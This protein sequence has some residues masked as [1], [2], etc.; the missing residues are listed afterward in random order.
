MTFF[1]IV[2]IAESY[3]QR[4]TF[5]KRMKNAVR[6]IL[7]AAVIGCCSITA[8]SETNVIIAYEQ[9]NVGPGGGWKQQTDG[10]WYYQKNGEMLKNCWHESEG[11]W[12][13]FDESGKMLTG[14]QLIDG[15]QYY[16]TETADAT[17]P[18]GSMY[19]SESTPDG[20]AVDAD[21]KLVPKPEPTVSSQQTALETA[22]SRTNPYGNV[23]CVEISLGNQ[24]VY[25]YSGTQCIF[26]SPC[27]TGRVI[28]GNATPAGRF[29]IYNK[30]RNRTLRGFNADGSKYA[31][32]VSFWMP[33][34]GGIG[35]HDATWR[36]NFNADVYY[37]YGS[38]GC[39]NMPY[40][41]AAALY[42]IIYVG[43]PVYVHG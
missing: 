39:I 41:K 31:S 21:G 12:Y 33:F 8:Y 23:S 2:W 15:A 37:N 43:M 4:K 7:C 22:A 11:K 34:N 42:N 9:S 18:L 38:H 40:D 20:N 16:L 29:K 19:V 32:F 36:T 6:F 24:L 25:A 27:V 35:L 5:M 10:S 14:W 26:A 30:E 13:R 1:G 28:N 3:S 17:H